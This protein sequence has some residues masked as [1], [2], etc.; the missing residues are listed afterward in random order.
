MRPGPARGRHGARRPDGRHWTRSM[1]DN[2]PGQLKILILTVPH[3]ASHQRASNALRAA[4]L[5]TQPDLKVE[6]VD[7][8]DHCT[9]WF[10][11]YYNSY[12]IP[13]KY[14]P[15]LWRWIENMQDR[16][17]ATSPGWLNRRGARPLFKF[18]EEFDPDLVV[19]TE[20]GICEFAALHKR[21]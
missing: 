14:W 6:V 3:G 18:I 7:A 16:K 20:V 13:L 9:R 1:E 4:L 21:S 10:R 17:G 2:R 12:E 11:A 8:L 19:A 5:E 15:G